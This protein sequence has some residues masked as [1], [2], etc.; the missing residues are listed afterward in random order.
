MLPPL[1]RTP[2]LRSL[3]AWAVLGPALAIATLLLLIG[4]ATSQKLARD[5]GDRILGNSSQ[6]VGMQIERFLSDA[7]STGDLFARRVEMGSLSLNDLDAWHAPI[8]DVLSTHPH[9]A[10]I[11][12]GDERNNAVYIQRMPHGLEV[13]SARGDEAF[14]RQFI[15]QPD[16][17]RSAEPN[18][19][20]DYLPSKR[21]W[22]IEAMASPEPR[23]TSVYTWFAD[24]DSGATMGSA[25]VRV[26]SDKGGK[27]L[28][29]VCV[30]VTLNDLS[31]YLKSI[32]P[33]PA[34]A[35]FV[36]DEQGLL[37]AASHGGVMRDGKRAA[38]ANSDDAFASR[39]GYAIAGTDKSDQIADSMAVD[40]AHVPMRVRLQKIA[41]Y[42]GVRWQIVA[43]IPEADLLKNAHE[44]Q[45]RSILL[46]S[47]VALGGVAVAWMI[48]RRISGSILAIQKHVDRVADGDFST[49]IKVG[50]ARELVELSNDL[51]AMS[52]DLKNRTELMQS[53][54]LATEVQQS[55]LPRTSPKSDYFDVFGVSTYCD[56]TGGDYFDFIEMAQADD[57][58]L[59][60]AIGDVM[61]HGIGSAMLM[62]SARGALRAVL[63]ENA[64]LAEA[65][66]R[67]NRIL[68]Q[69]DS[70]LF[71]TMTLM[72]ICAKTGTAE[73]ASAG[74][75][76]AIVYDPQAN[77]FRELDGAEVPLGLMHTDFQRYH[78]EG[79]KPG[80]IVMIGTDGVWEMKNQAHDDFGKDRMNAV[81]ATHARKPAKEIGVM[82]EAELLA[83]RGDEPV[84]DDVTYVIVKLKDASTLP[85]TSGQ[86]ESAVL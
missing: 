72:R 12:A 20:Y 46:A 26:A 10:A 79:L 30:D 2:S 22:F 8:L 84:H 42:P 56:Q 69:S 28:G 6:M 83:F 75:D 31:S 58:T 54:R 57:G 36:V 1:V 39:L 71:M 34:S 50:G 86:E 49:R 77:H 81:I 11:T 48:S 52:A 4:N 17:T 15:I 51:N 44:T 59:H 37:V 14:D 82:L 29:V 53:L 32:R 61:G 35:L 66:D 23:W 24:E 60:I 9:V 25:Y 55:L 3:V 18:R 27:P 85:A 5:L 19:T 63:L 78:A 68:L 7:V 80:M 16:G 13:C 41:P 64:N 40:V 76:A 45:R 62:A 70:G 43:A 74:H 38:M 21:P 65:L 47:V 73:W 33:T 67:V